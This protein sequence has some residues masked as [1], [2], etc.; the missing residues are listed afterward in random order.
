MPCA[1]DLIYE[2]HQSLWYSNPLVEIFISNKQKTP[3][4]TLSIHNN[5]Q[6]NQLKAALGGVWGHTVCT[7]HRPTLAYLGKIGY[8]FVISTNR[9]LTFNQEHCLKEQKENLFVDQEIMSDFLKGFFDDN[10]LFEVRMPCYT[11]AYF[12][13]INRLTNV[14]GYNSVFPVVTSNML[15][16]EIKIELK[17]PCLFE[18]LIWTQQ[19][20][21]E[22]LSCFSSRQE[23]FLSLMEQIKVGQR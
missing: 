3:K 14:F 2:K 22:I 20:D 21:C 9:Q 17:S 13:L 23:F 16:H 19:T 12:Q 11:D 10:F 7:D 4:P 8:P 15:Q 1:D 6:F 18:K 5:E